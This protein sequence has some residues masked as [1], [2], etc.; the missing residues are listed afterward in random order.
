M[1]NDNYKYFKEGDKIICINEKRLT[2]SLGSYLKLDEIPKINKIYTFDRYL[3]TKSG[4]ILYDRLVT[5][6]GLPLYEGKQFILLSESRKIKLKRLKRKLKIKN[7][8][9]RL[10]NIK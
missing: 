9:R 1:K 10:V 7:F 2:I 3:K 4:T 8:F 6:E 5:K